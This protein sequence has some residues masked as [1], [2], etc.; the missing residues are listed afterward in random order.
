MIVLPPILE[1]FFV[2]E[3]E[4]IPVTKDANT[5]GTAIS[6]SRLMKTVPKGAIQFVVNVPQPYDA[7]KTP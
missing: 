2:S 5:K 4:A 6:L 3:S 1:S 7:L